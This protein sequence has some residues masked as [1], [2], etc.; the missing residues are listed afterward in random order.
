MKNI[1]VSDFYSKFNNHYNKR[2]DYSMKINYSKFVIKVLDIKKDLGLIQNYYFIK[3]NNI[4]K[5]ICVVFRFIQNKPFF[6]LINNFSKST[7]KK[8]LSFFNLKKKLF[9]YDFIILINS[10]GII[11]S[12]E[13]LKKKQGGEPLL[14]IK[15]V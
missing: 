6:K 3:E 7:K 15:Y 8:T 14:G 4:I 10:Y 5:W 11:T 9:N 13:A 12:Y 1:S 2:Q